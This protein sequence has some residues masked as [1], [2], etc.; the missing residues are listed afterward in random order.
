MVQGTS[1]QDAE[2]PMG[3]GK[4]DRRTLWFSSELEL[5]HAALREEG[6]PTVGI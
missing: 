3:L 5:S 1:L 4:M 6:S 2:R